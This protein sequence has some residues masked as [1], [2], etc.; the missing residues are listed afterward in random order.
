MQHWNSS[1]RRMQTL[2]QRQSK[3]AGNGNQDADS[4]KKD[5][6]R[7]IKAMA[8]TEDEVFLKNLYQLS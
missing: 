1:I 8:T 3:T 6:F 2:S 7:C 5:F 4:N